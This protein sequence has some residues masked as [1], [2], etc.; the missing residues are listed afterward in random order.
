MACGDAGCL[1]EKWLASGIFGWLLKKNLHLLTQRFSYCA[2]YLKILSFFNLC[3]SFFQ[4]ATE[5]TRQIVTELFGPNY[6][7][8]GSVS[9]CFWPSGRRAK[10]VVTLTEDFQERHPRCVEYAKLQ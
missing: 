10:M 9:Y 4:M 7:I 1:K 8:K 3:V 6:L 2:E 5:L